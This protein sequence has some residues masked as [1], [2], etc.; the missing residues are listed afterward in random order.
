MRLVYA[1]DNDL[2]HNSIRFDVSLPN[3]KKPLDIFWPQLNKKNVP[4]NI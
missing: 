4:K 3:F 2:T 1:P